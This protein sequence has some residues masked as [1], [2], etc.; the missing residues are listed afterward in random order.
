[1]YQKVGQVSGFWS[2]GNFVEY[3]C[4]DFRFLGGCYCVRCWVLGGWFGLE[5]EIEIGWRRKLNLRRR[6]SVV[7]VFWEAGRDSVMSKYLDDI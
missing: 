5:C 3:C 2:I 6:V 4:I 7:R 1:M